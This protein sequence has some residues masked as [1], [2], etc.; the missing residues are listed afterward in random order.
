VLNAKVGT[1]FGDKLRSLSRYSSHAYSGHGGL[2]WWSG[3]YYMELS[4]EVHAPAALPPGP[5]SPPG[6]IAQAPTECGPQ[7]RSGRC[8]IDFNYF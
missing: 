7:S 1:N 2:L 6:E 8:G 5:P 4:G 3:D